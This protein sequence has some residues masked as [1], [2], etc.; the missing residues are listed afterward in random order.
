M[1]KSNKEMNN[2]QSLDK[3]FEMQAF[4]GD[5][6]PDQSPAAKEGAAKPNGQPSQLQYSIKSPEAKEFTL[7]NIRDIRAVA[8]GS[9]AQGPQQ[10]SLSVPNSH[11][12]TAEKQGPSRHPGNTSNTSS[13]GG[14]PKRGGKRATPGPRGAK[15]RLK[16]TKSKQRLKGSSMDAWSDGKDAETGQSAAN[17]SRSQ[18]G[19]SDAGQSFADASRPNVA[20]ERVRVLQQKAATMK[21]QIQNHEAENFALQEKIANLKRLYH[22]KQ[23]QV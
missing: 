4:D 21:A 12:A 15:D 16:A 23:D 6:H 2:S 5:N 17:V 20:P 1:S 7:G 3:P 14:R 9:P 13:L 11:Q 22:K 8:G 10:Y 19:T 18:A